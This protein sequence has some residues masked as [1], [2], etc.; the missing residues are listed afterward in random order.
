MAHRMYM[1]T[2]I[3]ESFAMLFGSFLPRLKFN[4]KTTKTTQ[5]ARSN[6]NT[7]VH[8]RVRIEVVMGP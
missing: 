3:K 2:R 4:S 7:S 1:Y 8:K 5:H 6:I